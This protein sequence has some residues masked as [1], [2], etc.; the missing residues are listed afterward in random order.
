MLWGYPV[1]LDDGRITN[2][3]QY[4]VVFHNGLRRTVTLTGLDGFIGVGVVVAC[5]QIANV[6]HH[7]QNNA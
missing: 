2:G 6:R 3:L 4:V 7:Y 5:M 1:E